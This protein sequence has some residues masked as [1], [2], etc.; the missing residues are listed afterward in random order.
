[1]EIEFGSFI[2]TLKLEKTLKLAETLLKRNLFKYKGFIVIM[3]KK[4]LENLQEGLKFEAASLP[5]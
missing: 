5:G 4:S 3:W 2:E 1:M